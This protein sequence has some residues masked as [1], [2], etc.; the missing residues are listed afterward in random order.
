M[1]TQ[2]ILLLDLVGLLL[3]GVIV[4]LVRRKMLHA[5]YAV[6]WLSAIIGTMLILSVPSLLSV[7]TR[8]VGALFPASAMTL[9]AFA[10]IVCNLVFISVKLSTLATRQAE[11]IQR[12]AL[13][14]LLERE[15]E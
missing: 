8:A 7:V 1:S 11:L 6:I 5:G 10:F 4:H 13:R 12:L 14:D 15:H 9:L 2:G 3:F